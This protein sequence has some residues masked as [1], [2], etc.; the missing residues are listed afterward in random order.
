MTALSSATARVEVDRC[1]THGVWFDRD[2]ITHVAHAIARMRGTPPP[3]VPGP[4]ITAGHVGGAAAVLAAGDA[5]Q[6]RSSSSGW[7]G[8]DTA[9]VAA[10]VAVHGTD[11]VDMGTD[12]ARAGAD[13][14]IVGVETVGDV[15]EASGGILE[16]AAEVLGGVLGALGELFS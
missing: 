12:V 9:D 15:A 10:E 16:G 8:T 4:V 11:L 1:D 5:L 14:A 13:V 3:A 2:E 7:S 6:R